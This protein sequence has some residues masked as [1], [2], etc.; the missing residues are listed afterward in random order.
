MSKVNKT[1]L[2]ACIS[3]WNATQITKLLESHGIITK[4][5][6]STNGNFFSKLLLKIAVF[7]NKLIEGNKPFYL[8]RF[9]QIIFI[10]FDI[11]IALLLLILRPQYFF[12]WSNM[13]YISLRVA[14]ILNI[15]SY[16]Y[17]GNASL[18]Y[19]IEHELI[20]C[21]GFYIKRQSAEQAIAKNIIVESKFVMNS[22]ESCYREK[23]VILP[24]PANKIKLKSKTTNDE[25]SIAIIQANKRKNT[26]FVLDV[27]E[28]LSKDLN[29]TLNIF[30]GCDISIADKFSY[31]INIFGSLPKDEYLF[32][33]SSSDLAL[34]PTLSDGGP[35]A[36]IE[37]LS[38]G[39]EV[40]S[41][42]YC[43]S[44]DL[45]VNYLHVLELN[46]E[47]WLKKIISSITKENISSND[48]S[49]FII[50]NQNIQKESF[51]KALYE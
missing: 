37:C 27:L 36:L 12:G 33:L 41:S 20:D 3:D 26:E 28:E 35:R 24:T 8:S 6:S 42:K 34:F 14:Q 4:F 51:H 7:F 10:T 5:V 23:V 31:K 44:P 32:K 49:E 18:K 13:S 19:D 16:L 47:V 2:V 17:Q 48:S 50:T 21:L 45:N 46:K 40:L 39:I 30:G 25:F 15:K 9:N 22:I 29:F 11:Y 38:L 1:A 43:I